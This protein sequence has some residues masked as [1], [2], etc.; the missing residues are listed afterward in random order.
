MRNSITT[1]V[2]LFILFFCGSI[3]YAQ[4]EASEPKVS[5]A[6]ELKLFL[7]A[8]ESSEI[9][10]IV[11][12]RQRYI[13]VAE[14][15]G[16]DGAKWYLI[17]TDAGLMG[18]IK[19]SNQEVSQKVDHYF[20]PVPIELSFP[21]PTEIPASNSNSSAGRM[22]VPVES[23]GSLVIVRVVFNHSVTA[24]LFLDTGAARTMISKRIARSLGV[25]AAGSQMI[26]GIGG[27]VA[28]SV[29]RVGSVKVGEAEVSNMTVSI[30]DFSPDPRIEGLLGFDFLNHFEVSL[31]ARNRQL[32]LTPR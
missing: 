22:A 2:A 9:V 13:P 15:T 17:K 1:A 29:A 14:V 30:H 27:G 23:N 3:K 12:E 5:Q 16:A 25:S 7:T 19:R 18:W 11:N 8:D 31:D 28:A 20:K 10:A 32:F 24:N 21:K 6:T 4:S 26:Y